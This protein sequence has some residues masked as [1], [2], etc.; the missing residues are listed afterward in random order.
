MT[1]LVG[2][3]ETGSPARYVKQLVSHAEAFGLK[4]RL[5]VD[6]ASIELE[7][8]GARL[9]ARGNQLFVHISGSDADAV[10]RARE[11][12]G[13]HLEAFGRREGLT[14]SWA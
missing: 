9:V 2:S 5:A 8:A 10:E 4:V 12:V 13:S 7:G 11:L 6:G 1:R 14:L 3:A